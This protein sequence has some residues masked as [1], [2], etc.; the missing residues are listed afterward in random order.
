MPLK[1]KGKISAKIIVVG[2]ALQEGVG[3]VLYLTVLFL[4]NY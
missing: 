3:V 2:L 4:F 1:I